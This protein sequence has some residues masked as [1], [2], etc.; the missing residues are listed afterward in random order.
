MIEEPTSRRQDVANKMT[1]QTF[2]S[3]PG[4]SKSREYVLTTRLVFDLTVAAAAGGYNLLVYLPTVDCDGVDVIF[5]DGYRVVP[6]QLKSIVKGGKASDWSVHRTLL[7]PKPEATE[8][9]GF[10]T[11]PTGRGG[12]VILTTVEAVDEATLD[13]AYAYTDI[14]VLSAIWFGILDCPDPQ[15]KR[16]QQLRKELQSDPKGSVDLPRSAFLRAR[17]PQH[18]LAVMGLTSCFERSWRLDLQSLLAQLHPHRQPTQAR[19][20]VSEKAHRENI[21]KDLLELSR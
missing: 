18:L 13:V 8:L 10:E 6:I 2:L 3:D 16:L 14:D 4:R 11:S 12:G 1:L 20:A 19:Q 15:N 5:D 21:R 9:Y 7:R 17:S